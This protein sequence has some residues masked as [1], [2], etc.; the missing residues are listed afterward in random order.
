M[1]SSSSLTAAV[2]PPSS[3]EGQASVCRQEVESKKRTSSPHVSPKQT[4]FAQLLEPWFEITLSSTHSR[5]PSYSNEEF[6]PIPRSLMPSN[7]IL[8]AGFSLQSITDTTPGVLPLP[9]MNSQLLSVEAWDLNSLVNFNASD[10]YHGL[11]SNNSP[12][13]NPYAN[14]IH[15]GLF[16]DSPV[17]A[18]N[19]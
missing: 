8:A 5:R 12:L 11:H 9:A 2:Q 17:Y 14:A 6:Q 3:I 13:Y 4:S 10:M 7:P 19:A 16:Y 1:A 18:P 15:H